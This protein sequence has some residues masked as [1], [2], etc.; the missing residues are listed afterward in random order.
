MSYSFRIRFRISDKVKLNIEESTISIFKSETIEINLHSQNNGC[1]IN[2]SNQLILIGHGY[3][4]LNIA[5]E[6]GNK[7]KDQLI[8]AFARLRFPADFGDGKKKG[9]LTAYGQEFFKKR[10]GQKILNDTI[11]LQVY[12]TNSNPRFLG[13]A[14]AI[15]YGGISKKDSLDAIHASFLSDL[16]LTD[17]KR[18]AFDLFSASSFTSSAD[19]KFILLMMAI[20]SLIEQD[21]RS[22]E[23]QELI[24]QLIKTVKKT[25]IKSKDSIISSLSNLK[26]ESIG[27]AGRRHVSK[28]NGKYMNL[29]PIQFF[30]YCYKLRSK[31][32]HGNTQRPSINKLNNISATLESFVNDLIIY[33]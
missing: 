22:Q 3:N 32:V 9:I 31:I 14:D 5:N 6:A 11:G 15:A 13:I 8:V 23:E 26:Y 33:T 30:S 10:T 4:T 2:N 20:E 27:S 25:K 17:R 16:I 21:E 19:S 24:Y 12:E 29:C 1:S 28:L 18:L 7:A